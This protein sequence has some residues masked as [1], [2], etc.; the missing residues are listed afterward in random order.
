[1]YLAEPN[2]TGAEERISSEFSELIEWGFVISPD[3]IME[4]TSE[5]ALKNKA[6]GSL[7]ADFN[8]Y[9]LKMESEYCYVTCDAETGTIL[10]ISQRSAPTD[11]QKMMY[12]RNARSFA[13]YL[14][15]GDITLLKEDNK[16][17]AI[18]YYY[19]ASDYN[20]VVFVSM[21]E[22]LMDVRVYPYSLYPK[23]E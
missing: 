18:E 7:R 8:A 4:S 22:Y 10:T 17:Y 12:E 19:F 20:M 16:L 15:L 13:K 11:M 3:F 5:F 14:D 23:G 1:M 6:D 9:I 2:K 21:G